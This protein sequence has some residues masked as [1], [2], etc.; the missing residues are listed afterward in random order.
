MA[1]EFFLRKDVWSWYLWQRPRSISNGTQNHGS[2]NFVNMS[3]NKKPSILLFH[4]WYHNNGSLQIQVDN[5][6]VLKLEVI[7]NKVGTRKGENFNSS[8]AGSHFNSS[9]MF[10]FAIDLVLEKQSFKVHNLRRRSRHSVV[11]RTHHVPLALYVHPSWSPDWQHL[12]TE[13]WL[14]KKQLSITQQRSFTK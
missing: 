6:D 11:L 2:N 3:F 5:I 10:W 8:I 9:G 13:S 1:L 7:S 4:S 12:A 14:A